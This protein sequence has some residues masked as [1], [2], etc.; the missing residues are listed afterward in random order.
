ML[1]VN[2][3]ASAATPTPTTKASSG[4]TISLDTTINLQSWV[5]IQAILQYFSPR[6]ATGFPCNQFGGQEPG[7]EDQIRDVVFN[8]YQVKFQMFGKVD[9]IGK[10]QH[11]VWK[12]LTGNT[13]NSTLL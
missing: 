10:N 12:H 9:I 8:K 3:A 5:R 7:A 11:P 4:S 1:V 13:N 2:V 6:F